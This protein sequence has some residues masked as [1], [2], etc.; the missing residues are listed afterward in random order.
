MPTAGLTEVMAALSLVTDLGS[1]FPPEKGLRT[2]PVA[3]AVADQAGLDDAALADVFQGALL[4]ALGCTS[5]ATENAGHFDDDLAFQRAVHTIDPANPSSFDDFGV[6]AGPERAPVLRGHF[7]AIAASVGPQ[8]TASSC[9]ASRALGAQ[10]G[11]RAGAI[12]SLDH[13][14]ERWDGLGIPEDVQRGGAAADRA[15]YSPR[16]AGGHRSSVGWRACSVRCRPPAF[17]WAP[18]SVA[19]RARSSRPGAGRRGDRGPRPAE[20]GDRRGAAPEGAR[21]PLASSI[22][23]AR[24]SRISPI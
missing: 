1:G 10:L 24:R 12:A 6:W 22:G 23:S 15:D 9:E 8:A 18:R 2:C 20:R 16:G 4:L 13:V 19:C 21:R 14:H 17:R 3:L 11:L 5:Y 7:F